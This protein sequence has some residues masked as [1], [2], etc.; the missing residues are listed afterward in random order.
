[1]TSVAPLQKHILP[2]FSYQKLRETH[3]LSHVS[4]PSWPQKLRTAGEGGD[5]GGPGGTTFLSGPDLP[6]TE[7]GREPLGPLHRAAGGAGSSSARDLGTHFSLAP[8]SCNFRQIISPIY[9][10]HKKKK[11]TYIF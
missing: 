7:P 1:M 10:Q 5:R 6:G 2:A 11:T 9:I 4:R 3:Q 8:E